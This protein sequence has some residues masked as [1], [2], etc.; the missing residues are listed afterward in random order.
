MN[1]EKVMNMVD[2]Q[3][4]VM[5]ALIMVAYGLATYWG[6]KFIL[7]EKK[8]SF[9]WIKLNTTIATSMMVLIYIYLFIRM[10]IEKPVEISWFSNIVI[11][12]VIL[13]LGASIA[14][15]CRARY[16]LLIKS[17]KGYKSSGENN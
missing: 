13:Y 6:I 8:A 16:L 7:L 11:R 9:T 4:I 5:M 10:F 1:L 17:R 3:T 14:A 12:P 2:I 15:G